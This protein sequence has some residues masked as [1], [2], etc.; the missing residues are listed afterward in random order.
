MNIEEYKAKHNLKEVPIWFYF[1]GMMFWIF[2]LSAIVGYLCYIFKINFWIG[3]T[4]IIPWCIFW[5]LKGYKKWCVDN[6]NK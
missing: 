3:F 4:I 6:G 1:Q 5:G 2:P